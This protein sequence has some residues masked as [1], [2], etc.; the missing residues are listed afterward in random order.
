M[1]HNLFFSSLLFISH[2]SAV[3][4]PLCSQVFNDAAIHQYDARSN[5]N[6]SSK[7]QSS[8][9]QRIEGLKTQAAELAE[10]KN[11]RTLSQ[12]LSQIVSELHDEAHYTLRMRTNSQT[13]F[14]PRE[15][16]LVDDFKSAAS[17]NAEIF[18]EILR[19]PDLA[20]ESAKHVLNFE[21]NNVAALMI[22]MKYA[23]K[24]RRT[25]EVRDA[26]IRLRNQGVRIVEGY[27]AMGKVLLRNFAYKEAEE[28]LLKALEV[29]PNFRSAKM[30]LVW[31]YSETRDFAKAR[32]LL[33]ELKATNTAHRDFAEIEANY[34]IKSGDL[35]QALVVAERQVA[36]NNNSIASHLQ[37]H[38]ILSTRG[39]HELAL[40][41]INRAA[42]ALPFDKRLIKATMQSLLNLNR[43]Q[44]VLNLLRK[45]DSNIRELVNWKTFEVRALLALNQEQKALALLTDLQ[46]PFRKQT[47]SNE[48]SVLYMT[49]LNRLRKYDQA[50]EFAHSVFDHVTKSPKLKIQRAL[51][52]AEL[53]QALLKT[54]D[55]KTALD[56][57]ERSVA[58]VKTRSTYELLL[59]C[60]KA[61]LLLDHEQIDLIQVELENNHKLSQ[62]GPV[63][64]ESESE[65]S[66]E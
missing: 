42:V 40:Q 34:F 57:A 16:A 18:S 43:P 6:L 13:E 59:E 36:F 31:V 66:E 39:Q 20:Y 14:T 37:I 48:L 47:H 60:H 12:I 63:T 46:P 24:I 15:A 61:Q 45:Q 11:F 21:P 32:A 29:M 65:F 8:K 56:F 50:L 2:A 52:F 38:Q 4:A 30:W 51:F 25:S 10:Q 49:T 7:A 58:L 44:E 41:Q 62:R 9:S 33:N 27:Y 3:A 23:E 1:F 54:G 26:A 53:A 64:V 28:S 19:R 22:V 17:V 5:S 55:A 35:D